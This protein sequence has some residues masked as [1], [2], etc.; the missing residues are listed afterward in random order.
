VTVA[1]VLLPPVTLLG[2]KLMDLTAT[3]G[4]CVKVPCTVLLA[5]VAVI[6]T[7]VLLFVKS[8]AVAVNVALVLPAGTVRVPGISMYG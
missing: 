3:P 5:R 6:V 4:V 2:L 1:V 7:V 8:S